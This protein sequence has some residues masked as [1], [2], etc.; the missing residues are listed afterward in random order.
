[1]KIKYIG[2]F[3]LA[4]VLFINLISC[5]PLAP[6]LSPQDTI[7]TYLNELAI[8]KDAVYRK[9]ALDELKKDPEKAKKYIEAGRT[10]NNLLWTDDSSNPDRRKKLLLSAGTI[11]TYKGYEIMSERIEGNS[12]FVE[13]VFK[14][15]AVFD[16]NMGAASA[17]DSKPVTYG[18]IKTQKGW[19]IK[20][21]NGI[22]GKMS[23]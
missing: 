9:A 23:R 20:D 8:F 3:I 11:V 5:V 13:V 14:K 12:A 22:L 1:M 2:K 7:K 4:G 16:R 21:I 10:I 17:Q 6:S 18:L 15:A 19:K